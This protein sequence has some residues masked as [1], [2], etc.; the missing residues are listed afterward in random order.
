MRGF[1]SRALRWTL[2]QVRRG[3]TLRSAQ[4]G[5]GPQ[6]LPGT[7]AIG[8]GLAVLP[9]HQRGPGSLRSRAAHYKE[10]QRH[11]L[12]KHPRRQPPTA[13]RQTDPWVV[14]FTSHPTW[15]AVE[16]PPCVVPTDSSH[17]SGDQPVAVPTGGDR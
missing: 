6:A 11:R 8:H 7:L 5:R 17:G 1:P 14:L 9:W 4:S 12:T 3:W 2:R 15:L 16:P 10:H 13:A